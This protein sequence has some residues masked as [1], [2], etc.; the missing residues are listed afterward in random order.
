MHNLRNLRKQ[1][2]ITRM[3]II[4]MMTKMFIQNFGIALITQDFPIMH[5][6]NGV[7]RKELNY[8]NF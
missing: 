6:E 1:V 3:H 7:A 5:I 4:G 8:E 2:L